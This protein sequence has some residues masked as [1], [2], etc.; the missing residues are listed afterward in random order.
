MGVS[1]RWGLDIKGLS[2]KDYK[3]FLEHL[4]F[5]TALHHCKGNAR[6]SCIV[7]SSMEYLLQ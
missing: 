2:V 5:I 4:T 1:I 6:L 7:Y 3:A